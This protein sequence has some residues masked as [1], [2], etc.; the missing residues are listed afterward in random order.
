[1]K[2]TTIAITIT[3]AEVYRHGCTVTCRGEALLAEGTSRLIVEGLPEGLDESSI[4]LRM[5]PV[6]TQGQVRMTVTEGGGDSP[7]DD[8][9]KELD[10]TIDEL[11]RKIENKQL[12]LNAWKELASKMGGSAAIEYLDRLPDMLDKLTGELAVLRAERRD[13]ALR[14]D[15]LRGRK[16]RPHLEVEVTAPSEATYPVELVCRSALAG[17]RPSYDVLVGALT[18][19]LRLRLKGQVWQQ[20]GNDWRDV[21]LR[22]STGTATVSG[23]LPRFVT[24]YLRKWEAPKPAPKV[25]SARKSMPFSAPVAAAAAAPAI[26]ADADST[27]V[28]DWSFDDVVERSAPQADVF[29]QATVTT[30]ELVGA[31]TLAQGRGGQTFEVATNQLAAKYY[32][33]SYPRREEAAYL[34]ARLESEPTPDVLEQ[35]L[36]VY[37]EGSYAGT[38]RVGRTADEEGYELPLGRDDRVRV[39]RTEEVRSSKRLLSG[40]VTR[41]YQCVITVENRKQTTLDL[42][43]LEQVP[44]STDKE[45]E[46]ELHEGHGAGYDAGRGELRWER[47]VDAGKRLSLAASYAV[48]HAKGVSVDGS[49][50]PNVA[51]PRAERSSFC[52]KCGSFVSSEATFCFVCGNKL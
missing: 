33:Y 47:T 21:T 46:V 25:Y 17:W 28:E 18:E 24:R 49:E 50:R 2:A 6:V 26:A 10:T 37:L 5:P 34:V 22:L 14:R 3:E 27:F 31:Q 39:R 13:L 42:V 32:Y 9:L 15:E 19:P 20:T 48:T 1:M 51:S 11:D 41:E 30:Y 35:P 8:E 40:K 12:E 44:V 16:E 43:V 36:A 23:D 7:Q 52:P 38:I 29:E 4:S 45:I